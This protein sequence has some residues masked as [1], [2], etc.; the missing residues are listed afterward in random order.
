MV[1]N[2]LCGFFYVLWK[3]HSIQGLAESELRRTAASADCAI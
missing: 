1:Q 2:G 3:L